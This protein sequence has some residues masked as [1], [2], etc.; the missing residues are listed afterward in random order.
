[1]L[2]LSQDELIDVLLCLTR[3]NILMVAF[4]SRK[5]RA[6]AD[7]LPPN[8]CLLRLSEVVLSKKWGYPWNE[9][10]GLSARIRRIFRQF[11]QETV[12]PHELRISSSYKEPNSVRRRSLSSTTLISA[13]LN[14]MR[15]AEIRSVRIDLPHIPLELEQML[16]QSANATG[17]IQEIVV[18]TDC[19]RVPPSVFE[20][21]IPACPR[22]LENT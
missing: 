20:V 10:S 2:L 6:A 18:H 22:G 5:L 8:T 13:F 4:A 9:R 15:N 16:R 7:S 21:C 3:L 1:M 19:R 12:Q 11:V 17:R 14:A